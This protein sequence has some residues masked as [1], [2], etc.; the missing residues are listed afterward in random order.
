ML[1]HV[2][3]NFHGTFKNV[4]EVD[5]FH[6]LTKTNHPWKLERKMIFGYDWTLNSDLYYIQ[7]P[8]E[9]SFDVELGVCGPIGEL[10][11]SLTYLIILK[12][13]KTLKLHSVDIE[14][15]SAFQPLIWYW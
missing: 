12:N 15:T 8:Y 3:T 10:L 9:F 4:H 11:E 14:Q 6:E 5:Y 7:P 1:N 2:D 13:I